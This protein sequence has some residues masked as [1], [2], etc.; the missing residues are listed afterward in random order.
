MDWFIAYL[1]VGFILAISIGVESLA[2]QEKHPDLLSWFLLLAVFPF[3]YPYVLYAVSDGS[4]YLYSDYRSAR[5]KR[6]AQDFKL[7]GC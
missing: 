5:S 7:Y 4:L 1:V 6:D 3:V 2:N